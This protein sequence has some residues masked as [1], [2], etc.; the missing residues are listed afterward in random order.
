MHGG[1]HISRR[2]DPSHPIWPILLSSSVASLLYP[3]LPLPLCIKKCPPQVRMV[4]WERSEISQWG[5]G[6]VRA[7]RPQKHFWYN[8]RQ[9]NVCGSN[10]FNSLCGNQNVGR[11]TYEVSG[12]QS[13]SAQTRLCE[14][15]S[16]GCHVYVWHRPGR[17][18]RSLGAAAR[19]PPPQVLACICNTHELSDAIGEC[20]VHCCFHCNNAIH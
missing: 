9:G 18:D 16:V 17:Q 15:T 20:T 2:E 12:P 11:C 3:M 7:A 19:V 8:S 1:N 6:W 5:L 4:V 13:A 14:G 10:Y